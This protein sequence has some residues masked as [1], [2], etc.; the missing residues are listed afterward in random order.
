MSDFNVS[1]NGGIYAHTSAVTNASTNKIADYEGDAVANWTVEHVEW[2]GQTL[3]VQDSVMIGFGI[4]INIATVLLKQATF[5]TLWGITA[6]TG[7]T[8]EAAPANATLYEFT[9]SMVTVPVN[10]FLI[11]TTRS[12]DSK[13]FQIKLAAGRLAGDFPIQFSQGVYITH[14]IAI[15]GFKDADDKFVTFIKEN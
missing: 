2:K 3:F 13:Q 12:S 11:D 1:L 6:T 10:E 15:V 4:T 7:S 14:D 9:T 8:L 5:N